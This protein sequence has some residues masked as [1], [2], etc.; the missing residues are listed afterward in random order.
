MLSLFNLK[1]L[2]IPVL[3]VEIG[4][5]LLFK[6]LELMTL[7]QGKALVIA[8]PE[9]LTVILYY[10][11][12]FSLKYVYQK[13][14]IDLKARN[15]K[16]WKLLIPGL[17]MLVIIS[18]F[19]NPVS[20]NLEI[21]YLAVGQGDGILIQFPNGE[22]MLIDTGPP[23]SD[24]RNVEYS[25]ISYLNYLGIKRLDYLLISHFDADHAGGIPHL[26][27]RKN[28]RTIMIPPYTEQTN[29]HL[30]LAAGIKK[31]TKVNILTAGMEFKISG[32]Q[33]KVL[34]PSPDKISEDRN[35]NSIVFLLKHQESSFL[36]TGDLSKTGEKRIVKN[37]NLPKIDILKAGHHGSKTS[38]GKI[39]LEELKPKLAVISVG[40]NNFGH[41]SEEV[42]NRFKDLKIQYLRTDQSGMIKI[43]SDG[44][45][46]FLNT[47]K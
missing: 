5:E 19:I 25:I 45:N 10:L 47:F 28:I 42:I 9:L 24:G 40:R 7:I 2:S 38:S 13:R 30:K 8:Q 46:I 12:L 23:G 36:F 34:N 22:K 16:I 1:I 11:L 35:E 14:Y 43:T 32:C 6:G 44:K 17:L 15:F 27:E 18:F 26:L 3:F 21:D 31:K 20:G 4:L 29:L 39:L 33:F 41:P 37:Y